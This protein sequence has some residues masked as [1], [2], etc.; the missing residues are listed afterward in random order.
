MIDWKV[1][2][3]RRLA[4]FAPSAV[5]AAAMSSA[6]AQ[7]PPKPDWGLGDMPSQKGRI[8]LVTG[9]TSGMGFEDAKAL[10]AA[11]AQV[12]IAARNPQRGQESIDRIKAEYPQALVQF[13]AVDLSDLSSVRALSQRVSEKL[14]R[15]DGLV[16]NAAIMAPPE[17]GTS[18][19]GMEMQFATNYAG[20]F[21]LTAELLPLLRKSEAPRVVTVASIAV[22]RGK[23][24]FDDLQ[25][26]K[27]YD[28]YGAYA[29]SKLAGLMFALEL[30]R[31][32]DRADWGIQSSAAHPGVAVTELVARGPG[33]ESETGRQWASNKHLFQTAAQGALPTL[34]ALTAPEAQGGTYYGPTGEKEVRGPLGVATLPAAANDAQVAARL[35][36]VTEGITGTRFP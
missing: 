35:W 32:S 13:E 31:R 4:A 25:S 3:S 5:C 29:Q 23:I 27:S 8:Y 21:A 18:A 1:S 30:Q 15:L 11:G 26:A 24:N 6:L 7:T 28:P 17:R 9:G 12:V 20:H 33:L 14:P 16:N 19:D 22:H 34:Y 2:V 36:A 10:A